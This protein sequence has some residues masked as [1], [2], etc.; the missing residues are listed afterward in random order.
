MTFLW[1]SLTMEE[2]MTATGVGLAAA[3]C[4]I[5]E[6]IIIFYEARPP[7]A[8]APDPRDERLC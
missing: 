3:G 1:S 6:D 2:A 8:K 4:G 5:N 7:G